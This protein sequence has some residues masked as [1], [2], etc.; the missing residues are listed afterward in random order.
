MLGVDP[1]RATHYRVWHARPEGL[2]QGH[3]TPRG[4]RAQHVQAHP[5]DDRGQPSAQVLDAARLGAAE[6]QPGFLDGVVRFAD[7]AEHPVGHR[8]QVTSVLLESL[9]Q[10]ILFVHRSHLLVV[11]RHC[12]DERNPADVTRR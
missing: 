7:R 4:A 10:P 9:C 6:T 2:A 1:I 11:F 3:H 8:P 5:S 12:S